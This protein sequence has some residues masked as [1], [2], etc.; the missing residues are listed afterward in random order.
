VKRIAVLDLET[1]PFEYGK[2]IHPF[3]AGFYDGKVFTSFWGSDCVSRTV[4]MLLN[5]S[6]PLMIYAHNGGRFDYFYFLRYM[7]QSL[8]IVNGR[9]IQAF[10]GKH[11]LRDSYAIMPFALETY[12]KTKIDYNL[13][14]PGI[15]ERHRQM[16]L[17]YLRND[18]TDLYTLVESFRSEFGEN[19]TIG[20]AAMKQLKKFHS[21]KTGDGEYD[22]RLRNNFYFGGRNQCFAAGVIEGPIKI[23]D[24]N[25]MYPHVMQSFLHPVSTGMYRSLKVNDNT[26]FL[27]VVGRNYGAFPVRRED[28][29]LDFT[30]QHGSFTPTI[31]EWNA[32]METGSFKCQRI[33]ETFGYSIRESFSDFVE[34]FY[35]ARALAKQNKDKIKTIF[36]KYVLNSAYGK[37]AQNPENYADWF[38]TKIGEHPPTWHDCSKSCDDPCRLRWTPSYMCEDYMIWEKP[39][40]ELNWYNVATGASIT[41]AA[42]SVLLRGIHATRKVLYVDTDSII[43]AGSS[44]LELSETKLGSWKVEAEGTRIAICGKKLYAVFNDKVPDRKHECNDQCEKPCPLQWCVKKAHKGARLTGK[45]ILDIANGAEIVAQNPVPAFKWDGSHSFTE[46]KIRTTINL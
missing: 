44:T 5:V 2:M 46:R 14:K 42:R 38:I 24:V 36:Y 4:Q 17:D 28:G 37:F 16:I 43:C 33:I 13:F 39:L 8:R 40:A 12:N 20:S 18:C 1:D 34:H 31:H 19:L 30:V 9:I 45:Q 41:G 35:N 26:C 3:A 11:E 32:A 22:A 29:S 15:R 21:F 27:R 6:E 7:E 23:Y 25:S 10:L